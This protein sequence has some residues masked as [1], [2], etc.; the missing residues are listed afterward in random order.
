MEL[1]G[2]SPYYAP[3][4]CIRISTWF[5]ASILAAVYTLQR[6]RLQLEANCPL[7]GQ[8]C[9]GFWDLL[10]KSLNALYSCF[11]S[12]DQLCQSLA[13]DWFQTQT[14][15]TWTP[16]LFYSSYQHHNYCLA[17]LSHNLDCLKIGIRLIWILVGATLCWLLL[18]YIIIYSLEFISLTLSFSLYLVCYPGWT[19]G[20][21][22]GPIPQSAISI[23]RFARHDLGSRRWLL[24]LYWTRSTYSYSA[25]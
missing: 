3:C 4:S 2:C 1:M 17:Y 13:V 19:R 22:M 6:A 18:Y 14:I 11:P 12:I 9:I 15:A 23:V 20:S 5:I 24:K 10:R 16:A 21:L 25:Q 7:S 8:S